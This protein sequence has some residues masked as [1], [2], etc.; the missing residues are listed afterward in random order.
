MSNYVIYDSDARTK[1]LFRTKYLRHSSDGHKTAED[2]FQLLLQLYPL[3]ILVEENYGEK[4]LMRG[5]DG[6]KSDAR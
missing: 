4:V 3:A 6:Q 1:E 5:A 2:A